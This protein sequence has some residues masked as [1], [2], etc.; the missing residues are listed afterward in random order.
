[1]WVL[2]VVS[3]VRDSRGIPLY[4]VSQTEDITGHR[5]ADEKLRQKMEELG[6][7]NRIAVGRELKMI[8]LKKKLKALEEGKR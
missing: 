1:V 3:L 5:M 8:E 6:R 2:S 4:F 7:F